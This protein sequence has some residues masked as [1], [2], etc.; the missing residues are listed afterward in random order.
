MNGTEQDTTQ[1]N[2]AD[3]P[4]GVRETLSEVIGESKQLAASHLE[5]RMLELRALVE[6]YAKRTFAACVAVVLAACGLSCLTVAAVLGVQRQGLALDQA[7][8]AV[9]GG[10]FL[11]TLLLLRG[12]RKPVEL[13]NN[14]KSGNP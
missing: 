10:L 12:A 7:A 8:A 9:G 6:A 13:P 2:G 1:R 14:Q 5:L 4:P 3:V 11:V